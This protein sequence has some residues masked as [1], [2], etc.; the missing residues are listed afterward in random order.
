MGYSEGEKKEVGVHDDSRTVKVESTPGLHGLDNHSS[1]LNDTWRRKSTATQNRPP[2][3][4]FVD[5]DMK[6]DS[7][8]SATVTPRPAL[9]NGNDWDHEEKPASK[10]T[11]P[12]QASSSA[13]SDGSRTA[14][15][16]SP[17]H[18]HTESRRVPYFRYFGT[19][20]IVPGFKK[21]LVDVIFRKSHQSNNFSKTYSSA[22]GGHDL[23]S[24]DLSGYDPDQDP[25]L[26]GGER[27]AYYDAHSPDP[28][29]PL[30]FMLVD[31][32]F[33][34]L[35][36]NYLF[37]RK[38]RFVRLLKEKRLE[39]ILV[40]TVCAL[41]A[42]FV[43]H[44][45]LIQAT[46]R[47][48]GRPVR[49]HEYGHLYAQRAKSAIV[50]HFPCP[51]VAAV[52]AALLMAYE[53]FG[54]N[55][56]SALWMYLGIAI[57]MVLDLGLQRIEG[58]KY[59][60][61]RDPW[62]TRFWSRR[63]REELDGPDTKGVEDTLSPEEQRE[64]E[65]ERIDTFWA[66]F[67]LDRVI[68]S[69][70]GR[71]VT[72]RDD[73]FDLSLPEPTLDPNTGWP[74]PFPTFSEIIHLYGR[75]SD[76]L[77]N[78]RDA[79][80]L[81]EDKMQKL[82]RMESDL[83][84]LYKK[85]DSRLHFNPVNFRQY[86]EMNQGTTFILLHFWFH[87]LI[88]VLHQPTLL[89]P[90]HDMKPIQLLPNSPQLSMSSAKTIAD[91]LAFAELIDPK[92]LV[93]NPFTSQPIY[94][95]ACAFLMESVANT[96]T[97]PS[98]EGTPVP[99]AK[100]DHNRWGREGQP[101][102]SL[103]AHAANENYQR[104]YK[105]LQELEKYWA[106]VGYILNALDQ[107]SKGIWDCEAFSKDESTYAERELR[108]RLDVSNSP[109]PPT[110]PFACALLTGTTNSPN[111]N[112][113]V[114]L[115][116]SAT[117]QVATATITLPPPSVLA[118]SAQVPAPTPPGNMVYDPIRQS[119]PGTPQPPTYL[120]PSIGTP[121]FPPNTPRESRSS[122][123]PGS[124]KLHVQIKYEMSPP[125][126]MDSINQR[127]D[128]R[129]PPLHAASGSFSDHDSMPQSSYNTPNSQQH[130]AYDSAT[131]HDRSSSGTPTDSGVSQQHSL[132]AHN[133]NSS[134]LSHHHDQYG[135]NHHG[136]SNH[137][138]YMHHD[139]NSASHNTNYVTGMDFSQSN[140][141]PGS[142]VSPSPSNGGGSTGFGMLN[143]VPEINLNDVFELSTDINI[144]SLGTE[145]DTMVA[146]A[147]WLELLP[148]ER[149]V[150]LF[151][152]GINAQQGQTQGQWYHHGRD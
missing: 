140:M 66:V 81:T 57:R 28:V 56:D 138:D 17:V 86:V 48:F 49:K 40:D 80:D 149:L 107:K 30:I 110:A 5:D 35:G 70:T 9:D 63:D 121:R 24:K 27:F 135:H 12:N 97:P 95:A 134:Y 18:R 106:G 101:K 147:P 108:S 51:S 94:I 38:E 37:L 41:A 127:G 128:M 120:Q 141:I 114:M 122:Q 46:T 129:P 105:S 8:S 26:D 144:E 130:S 11:P 99:D 34:Q 89:T 83:T 77:N 2:V 88:I 119:L 92:S 76:V 133:H 142:G 53:A 98:R 117:A 123:S 74:A 61:E 54:A 19:T 15:N 84:A 29:P 21:V 55:Q 115:K 82:S 146:P 23:S 36:C 20:A 65:Q 104:C 64:V 113:T 31:T 148:L 43:E 125:V 118:Q 137:H 50:D 85:Q 143:P 100:N 103:L 45:T 39:P 124:G 132:P 79:S 136:N 73:D 68:S 22:L 33:R 47:H 6:C 13:S 145:S 109:A 52:Q 42:R 112:V 75:V 58:I 7:S 3:A 111:T 91:I 87:A 60:G 116:D 69:S 151:E 71:P 4:G 14:N 32:F 1:L 25:P 150:G 59:R 10:D 139:N 67:V 131:M 152:E 93:G 16:R 62:Y 96:S 78:I 90:F 102:H 126:D 72:F 44:P